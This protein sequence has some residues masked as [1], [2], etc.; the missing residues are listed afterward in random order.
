MEVW[1]RITGYEER[2]E[3]SSYGRVRS[4]DMIV[5]GRKK[6]CHFVKGR[7][8]KPFTD[9]DGYK[10]IVL[11]IK[12]ERKTYRLH[13][14]VAIAFIPNPNNLPEIDH[15]DGDKTNNKIDNLRWVTRKGN[16]LNPK[17][18]KRNSDAKKGILNPMHH[19][20][21]KVINKGR[22]RKKASPGK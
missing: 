16:S 15:I 7:I 5:N 3:V 9:K 12:Q 8:L 1:K 10:G 14:I 11:C 19:S 21:R 4:N 13:R 22:R 18:R 17:T 20:N 2:Y 6:N